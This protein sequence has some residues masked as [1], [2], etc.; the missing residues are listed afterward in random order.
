MGKRIL[1]QR[2]GK[3]GTQF[4]APKVGKLADARYPRLPLS[5]TYEAMVKDIVHERGRSEPLAKISLK[6]SKSEIFYI[7]AVKGL[8]VGQSILLGPN[9]PL[10]AGNILPLYKIPEG[11]IICNI[12]KN[13]GDGGKLVKSSGTSATLV[14]H[15]E[16]GALI[17]L[18]SGKSLYVNE[19]CRATIGQIAGGGRDEKPFLKAG[20][21]YHLMRAK[22]RKYPIPKGVAMA[23]VYH[24]FGGAYKKKKYKT[25]SRNAPPGAKVGHIAAKQTGRKKA[26]RKVTEVIK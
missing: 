9:A 7:P 6:N 24:P 22:G 15:T 25:V 19:K 12:E 17:T 1:V 26:R 23:A 18:P 13:F 14:S 20:N 10:Q 3:G 21:R 2:R 8:E 5:D 4:R 11:T 16:R